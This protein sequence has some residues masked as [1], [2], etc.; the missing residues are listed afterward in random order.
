MLSRFKGGVYGTARSIPFAPSKYGRCANKSA[1]FSLIRK[2]YG[3]CTQDKCAMLGKFQV[4]PPAAPVPVRIQ[5]TRLKAGVISTGR[6]K[7]KNPAAGSLPPGK[8]PSCRCSLFTG[9][10]GTSSS[11]HLTIFSRSDYWAEVQLQTDVPGQAGMHVE[12]IF[13]QAAPELRFFRRPL[14]DTR[15]ADNPC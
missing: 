5:K 4:Q 15:H 11:S 9:G 14:W 13:G 2:L 3:H 8:A 6:C 10:S 12:A 1:S 7:T